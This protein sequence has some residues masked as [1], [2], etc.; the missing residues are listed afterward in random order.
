MNETV[1]DSKV[2]STNVRVKNFRQ[3]TFRILLDLMW[4]YTP[5]ISKQI[6]K[7]LF[8]TPARYRIRPQE[9]RYLKNSQALEIFVNDP[10]IKSGILIIHDKDD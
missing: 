2:E 7:R 5:G 9:K 1:F 10:R 8:F 4:R 6:V 3:A